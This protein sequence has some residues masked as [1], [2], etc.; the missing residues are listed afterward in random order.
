MNLHSSY[1]S[2][3]ETLRPT[4]SPYFSPSSFPH[5]SSPCSSSLCSS[6]FAH[7]GLPNKDPPLAE[8]PCPPPLLGLA[9][10]L[11]WGLRH[12]LVTTNL[13]HHAHVWAHYHHT[14]VLLVRHHSTLVYHIPS[15]YA[16]LALCLLACS[17]ISFCG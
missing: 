14:M 12:A 11:P 6:S 15:R 10:H 8:T 5:S 4:Y 9:H 3:P 7:I 13:C 17:S 2:S 16:F 1:V